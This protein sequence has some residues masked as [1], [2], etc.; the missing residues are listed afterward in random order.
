MQSLRDVAPRLDSRVGT[1]IRDLL[2]RPEGYFSARQQQVLDALKPQLSLTALAAATDPD[3][4][5]AD[6]LL[7]N[8]LYRRRLGSKASGRV[9]VYVNEDTGYVV[10]VGYQVEVGGYVYAVLTETVVL[11]STDTGTGTPLIVAGISDPAPYLFYLTVYA[12]AAG[13][14]YNL[15]EA[16]TMTAVVAR[17]AGVVAIVSATAITGGSDAQTV[18]AAVADLPLSLSYRGFDSELAIKAVINDGFDNRDVSVIGYNHV[19]QWR[20]RGNPYGLFMP[21]VTDVYIAGAGDIGIQTVYVTG[22]HSGNGTYSMTLPRTLVPGL[23]GVRSLNSYVSDGSVTTVL[24][25]SLRFTCVYFGQ[26]VG[27]SGHIISDQA[28]IQIMNSL[29]QAVTV[30]VTGVPAP[31]TAGVASYPDTLEFGVEVYVLPGL[32]DIQALCDGEY[33]SVNTDIVVRACRPCF[34]TLQATLYKRASASVDIEAVAGAVI[35]YINS[36]KFGDVVAGS[37]IL[38]LLHDYDIINVA[39]Q[40]RGQAAMLLT[41]RIPG[42][43]GDDVVITGTD[44]RIATAASAGIHSQT[45][46]FV[47]LRENIVLSLVNI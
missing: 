31:V 27:D 47:G 30:T 37:Q 33:R 28:A 8:F 41:G 2:L 10:P 40:G 5:L 14:A 16:T 11:A 25:G 34:V 15:P 6:A 44:L 38:A 21:G 29:W 12:V 42:F 7:G 20:S 39:V 24:A 1:A 19:V 35:S 13:A 4:E 23:Q 22:T 43:N 18:A 9:A 45:V 17:L 3:P 36:K 46:A 32:S 26:N